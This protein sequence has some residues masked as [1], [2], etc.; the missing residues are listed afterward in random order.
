[1]ARQGIV[2]REIPLHGLQVVDVLDEEG[3]ILLAGTSA[4]CTVLPCRLPGGPH[5]KETCSRGTHGEH[6]HCP[7]PLV[8][9]PTVYRGHSIILVKPGIGGPGPIFRGMMQPSNLDPVLPVLPVVVSFPVSI[10]FPFRSGSRSGD[11][12][13][14]APVP[15]TVPVRLPFR[16]LFRSGSGP[17]LCGFRRC[18]GGCVSFT[19]GLGAA[20][21]AGNLQEGINSYR[22]VRMGGQDYRSKRDLV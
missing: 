3:I 5:H 21:N 22:S 15:V 6:Y 18:A 19:V 12:S 7:H 11:C 9:F 4:E 20:E 10:Q 1:M 8:W 2:C 13:G 14:P 17:R 16:W